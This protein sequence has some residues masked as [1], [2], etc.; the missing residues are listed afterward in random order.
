MFGVVV[1]EFRHGEE[2]GPVGLLV[3]ALDL[4]VLLED[5][6]EPFCLAICLGMEGGRPVGSDSQKFDESS[7][8]VGGE[9]RVSVADQGFGQAMK[10]DD[11]LDEERH[12]V[13]CRHGFRGGN[14]VRHLGEAIDD[15]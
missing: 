15:H 11:V 8:E 4:Q 2:A 7:P 10:P 3:V 13:L 12:D 14:E 5:G 1:G 6:V 9:D